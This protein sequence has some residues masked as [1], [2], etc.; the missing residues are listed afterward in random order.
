MFDGYSVSTDG[1]VRNDRNGYILKNSISVQG[2]PVVNIYKHVVAVHKLVGEAFIPNPE[3][4]PTINHKDGNRCNNNINNLEW[5]T[6]SENNWHSWNI[7]DSSDRRAEI[8]RKIKNKE[9]NNYFGYNHLVN[10]ETKLKMSESKNK[11][12]MCIETGKIYKNALEASHDTYVT[13]QC[14]THACNGRCKTAGGYH[15]KYI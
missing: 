9:L 12:L 2:Y 4:K 5:A 1:R 8:S 11:K 10:T 3:N 14:I 15:W 13:K 7:I 6:Y